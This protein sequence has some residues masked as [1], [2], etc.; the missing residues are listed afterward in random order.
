[1]NTVRDERLLA[2]CVGL[3]KCGPA[4][5]PVTTE[6]GAK[7]ALDSNLRHESNLILQPD[8]KYYLVSVHRIQC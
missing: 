1:M 5:A 6:L 3:V 8:T 4:Q 7:T 2:P